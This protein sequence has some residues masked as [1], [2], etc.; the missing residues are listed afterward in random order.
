MKNKNECPKIA[1]Y[2]S[3][4]CCNDIPN[5]C[6]DFGNTV[7]DALDRL[8]KDVL[9]GFLIRMPNDEDYNKVTLLHYDSV[10]GFEEKIMYGQ[11]EVGTI[12]LK[13]FSIGPPATPI[14]ISYE[15]FKPEP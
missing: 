4:D 2:V 15:P 11:S 3:P 12:T 6:T 13:N 9:Y 1:V 14:K 5:I 7:A 8:Y 10:D